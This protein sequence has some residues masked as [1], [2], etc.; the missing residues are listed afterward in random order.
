MLNFCTLFNSIYLTRGLVMYN[1]LAK[2]CKDFHLYI[3][4]FDDVSYSIL[5][6]LNLEKATIISLGTFENEELLS[7]KPTRTTAEYCWTC[8]P[9]TVEYC[10]DTYELPSCTY[11]DADLLFFADPTVLFDELGEDDSVIITDHRYTPEYD[12]TATSGKYCVQFVYFKNDKQGRT[13]LKWWKDA[14]IEWCY[15]RFED[16]KFGDQKYLD[17]WCERFKGVHELQHLGGGVAPWN[18]Q[19]YTISTVGDRLFGKVNGTDETF[20]LIFYHFHDLKY[21]EKDAFH[22]GHYELTHG[23]LTNIYKPYV[24]ALK[25]V[26]KE[27]RSISKDN[28]FHEIKE[29]PRIN[30]SLRRMYRF[31][32]FGHLN[33]YYKTRYLIK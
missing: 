10:L 6:E 8:T 26:E 13:V 1:S 4:A 22:L 19:Q 9:A 21:C 12:Q 27:L 5:N 31:H 28:L 11:I 33:N 17:D 14:C 15:N 25:E 24:I 23:H 32:V 20:D 18:A 16:N 30:K 7:I 3:F 29:I 2:H